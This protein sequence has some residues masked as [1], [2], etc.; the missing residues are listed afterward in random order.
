MEDNLKI[1][2]SSKI[3]GLPLKGNIGQE[4]NPKLLASSK[5]CGLPL[6]ENIGQENNPKILAS[7]KIGGLPHKIQ[8]PHH[9]G[10]WK[11]RNFSVNFNRTSSPYF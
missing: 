8:P 9:R 1:L 4:N 10:R 5:I 7:Y 11:W 2:E 6:K 3:C